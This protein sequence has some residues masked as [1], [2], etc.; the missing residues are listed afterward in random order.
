MLIGPAA[1]ARQWT[2]RLSRMIALAAAFG[3]AAGVGGAL[4]SITESRLPTGP[5]IILTLTVIVVVSLA[6]GSAR[7][8]VWEWLRGRRRSLSGPEITT[9]S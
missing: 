7:G 6:F 3:A 8:L 9:L 1:A 5:L 4:L 2:D